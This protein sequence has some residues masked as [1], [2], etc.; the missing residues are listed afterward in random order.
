MSRSRSPPAGTDSFEVSGRGELQLGVL[1]ETLQARGLRDVDRPARACCTAATAGR[2][3]EPVEEVTV[4]VDEPYAGVVVEGLSA[5][6]GVVVEMRPGGRAKTRLILHVPSRGLIGY[7]GRFLS[8]TRGTGAL[9]R[10]FHAWEAHRGP[11]AGRRTGVLV[12]TAA[13]K[14]SAY[15]LSQ[16]EERG[17]VF[18]APG[19]T[20]YTRA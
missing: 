5:R 4:D 15:A 10:A 14:A 9:N 13:G 6:R 16:L 11:I 8:D 2:R 7:H 12:A 20:V 17:P 19:D 1:I 3:L 18:V